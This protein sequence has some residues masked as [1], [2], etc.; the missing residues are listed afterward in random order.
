MRLG[1]GFNIFAV[2][3]LSIPLAQHFQ[4]HD[5]FGTSL[6]STGQE[7]YNM[8]QETTDAIDHYPSIQP[9]DPT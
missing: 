6:S 8:E 4:V 9:A 1:V 3:V 2:P 7:N 5:Q